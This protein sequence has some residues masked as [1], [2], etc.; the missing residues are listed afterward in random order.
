MTDQQKNNLKKLADYL[1]SG[2]LKAEF[3]ME[4]Y[5]KQIGI[6]NKPCGTV[7]CAAGHGPIIGI[8]KLQGEYWKEYIYRVFGINYFHA[9]GEA[10]SLEYNWLFSSRWVSTDN[11]AA[12]AGKRI[13]YFLEHG[14]PKNSIAQMGGSKPLCY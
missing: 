4:V 7:A 8:E 1:L 3:D 14:V 6:N 10:N 2:K 11:T 13:N 9:C 12:G 5:E